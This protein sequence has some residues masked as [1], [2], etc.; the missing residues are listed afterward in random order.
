MAV[1]REIEELAGRVRRAAHS[2]QQAGIEKRLRVLQEA[3]AQLGARRSEL[4]EILR[5]EGMSEDLARDYAEWVI[6]A[7]D[8][9]L[10]DSYAANMVRWVKVGRGGELLVRRADGVVLIF[11]QAGSPTFN[12][13]PIFSI[14]L[15]GNG[16]IA[17]RSPFID[18]GVRFIF[19]Q[20]V[21][22]ALQKHGFSKDLVAVFT[23][24]YREALQELIETKEVTTV[25]SI[26]SNQDNANIAQQ[27]HEQG[28]KAILEHY[29]RGCMVVWKDAP[30][31]PAVDSARRAFDLSTRPCFVPKHFLIHHEIFDK[32]T[33]ALLE[34]MPRYS[35]TV[36]GDKVHG[37]LTPAVQIGGYLA[38]LKE[39]SAVGQV[40]YGGYQMNAAGQRDETGSFV[41]P[42]IVTLNARDCFAQPLQCVH[43]ELFYPLIPVIRFEGEDATIAEQMASLIQ[44]NPVGL[45]T[46]V[47]TSTPSIIE[48]F[49]REISMVSLLR[50]NNDHSVSPVYASFWGGGNGDNHLFWEKTSHQQAIDC[51]KLSAEEIRTVWA[52]LG[53][54]PPLGY[55]NGER[56]RPEQKLP[57]A[58]VSIKTE[59]PRPGN[60]A[61]TPDTSPASLRRELPGINLR[62]ENGI[63]TI[64]FNRPT[65]HNSINTEIR[66]SLD[67]VTA[68][69]AELG[70]QLRCV[71]V[72][73]AG[74][75]FC[76]GADLKDL[77]GFTPEEAK[78]YMVKVTWSFRRLERLPVPVLAAVKGYC[79]GGGFEMV[80]HCDEII[81]AEDTTFCFPETGIGIA[82]TTGAAARLIS[83]V[84]TM[85]ARPLL[86]GTR[87]SAADGYRIGLVS[88]VVPVGELESE[89][90]KRC[91]EI[92]RQPPEGVA[93]MKKLIY[94]HQRDMGATSWIAELETFEELV[95][96]PWQRFVAERLTKS[97]KD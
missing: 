11:A 56:P 51:S 24:R 2:W 77:T 57:S 94:E 21:Q 92:L 20:I 29:G 87:F 71:V 74:A 25:L 5:A 61:T 78:Q 40:A 88:K 80:L 76:S 97:N 50:F 73:G 15:P 75:S 55:D 28:K 72:T 68:E 96:G 39:A 47:W 84:G 66:D 41:S 18:G 65:R 85:R 37:V 43:Q 38:A 95:K 90:A 32:F 45:R 35:K 91:R 34:S 83:I 69:L 14:L 9:A 86:I 17:V 33:A 53:C 67:L 79:M 70:A 63:A 60:G 6:H 58:E 3:G 44:T 4:C 81:A 31:A 19:E 7:G 23:E 82:T 26:G 22:P 62:L 36:E 48:F 54:R 64:E 27:C 89:V 10:L 8:P 46:S 49:A 16:A 59:S 13:A 42:T 93:A 30:V 1:S 52:G 12:A